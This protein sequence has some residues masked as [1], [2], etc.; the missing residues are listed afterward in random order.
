MSDLS[1]PLFSICIPSYNHPELVERALQSIIIQDYKNIEVIVSDDTPDDLVKDLV[2]SYNAK[3]NLIYYQNSSP[4]GSPGNWNKA[5]AEAKGEFIML[6]HHDDWLA[7]PLTVAACVRRLQQNNNYN[8]LFGKSMA[9][10]SKRNVRPAYLNSFYKYPFKLILNNIIG[11][12]SNVVMRKSVFQ[13]YDQQYKWLVDLEF[14]IRLILAG[15]KFL[16]LD[17]KIADIGVHKDQVTRHCVE[18]GNIILKENILIFAQYKNQMHKDLKMYDQIWR[19]LRNNH[20]RGLE[21]IVQ[22]G[23]QQWGLPLSLQHMVKVQSLIPAQILKWGLLS[24]AIMLFSYFT[25]KK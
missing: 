11:P 2:L 16:Y 7:G 10:E 13:R 19:L 6:L 14:Y 23:L 21:D 25:R 24:K 15:H 18:D 22:M 1:S 9:L 8:I 5:L 3:L 12:P 20:I 4:L 17:Q